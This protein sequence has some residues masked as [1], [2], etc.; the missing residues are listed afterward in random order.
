[1]VGA[2]VMD[3]MNNCMS[4]LALGMRRSLVARI[5]CAEPATTSVENAP[6]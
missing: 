4:I 6:A 1:V 5:F 3:I 2:F